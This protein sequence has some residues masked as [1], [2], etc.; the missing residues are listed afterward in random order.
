LDHP[1]S[2]LFHSLLDASSPA[3]IAPAPRLPSGPPSAPACYSR[4]PCAIET[5]VREFCAAW[6]GRDVDVILAWFA[7]DAVYHN[8]PIAPVRGHAEIRGVL[9]MFVPPASKIEFEILAV[10]SSGDVVFTER[11][12]RFVVDGKEIALPVAGVFEVR[13]G[14]IAAWRDYFDMASY[15]RQFG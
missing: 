12:D 13:D 15:Q 6:S 1:E 5:V 8:M 9:E 2:S 3:D 11:V 7:A 4:S 14:K 10:A